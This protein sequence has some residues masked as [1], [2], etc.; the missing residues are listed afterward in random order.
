MWSFSEAGPGVSAVPATVR[1]QPMVSLPQGR[2]DASNVELA[3]DAQRETARLYMERAAELRHY[4]YALTRN[5]ELARDALQEAFMRYFVALCEGKRIGAPRAWLYRVTHNYV[6]DRRK[7]YRTRYEQSIEC[8]PACSDRKQDV[9][10]SCLHRELLDLVRTTLTRREL[11]CF[12]LRAEGLEYA[13]IASRL[14]LS[15]GTVGALISR[16]VH[17]IR[18]VVKSGGGAQDR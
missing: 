18:R 10:R 8:T 14:R 1:Q 6:K 5:E 12:Q 15:S 11:E 4:A 13:E 3:E 9:E 2:A 16:A 7:E 17:R